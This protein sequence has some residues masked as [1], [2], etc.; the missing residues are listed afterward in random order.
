MSSVHR[1]RLGP[2]SG[3]RYFDQKMPNEHQLFGETS[4]R[5]YAR[6]LP[7]SSGKRVSYEFRISFAVSPFDRTQVQKVWKAPFL[8][9]SS[10]HCQTRRNETT[11]ISRGIPIP[12]NAVICAPSDPDVM[13]NRASPSVEEGLWSSLRDIGGNLKSHKVTSFFFKR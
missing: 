12:A 1:Y 8:E 9:A 11:A 3:L 10:L 6:A 2:F 4:A 13:A 7:A 5:V